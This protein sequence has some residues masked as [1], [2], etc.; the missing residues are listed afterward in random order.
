VNNIK[1]IRSEVLRVTQEVLAQGI[2]VTQGNVSFY[3]N[4]QTMPPDVAKRLIAFAESRG[5][6][7]TFNDIYGPAPSDTREAA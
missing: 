5:H 3:E 2:G 4:G 1:R 7:V 6:A